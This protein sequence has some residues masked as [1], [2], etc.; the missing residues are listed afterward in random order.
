[1]MSGIKDKRKKNDSD[2]MSKHFQNAEIVIRQESDATLEKTTQF[3][4]R[5]DNE[6]TFSH[7]FS[8]NDAVDYTA[9]V[10][11]KWAR[12]KNLKVKREY[13]ILLK[14]N[15][16]LQTSF[17]N[18]EVNVSIKRRRSVVRT[19]DNSFDETFQFK[20][21]RSVVELKSTN[22]N[23]YYDKSYKEFKNWIRNALNAFEINSFYFLNEWKKIRWTQQY[24][25]KTSS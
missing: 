14:K 20:R 10:E 17:Q 9:L 7:E 3:K 25:R 4:T 18:D 5:D 6:K 19:S 1:M 13:Q 23:L 11:K 15:K 22:L 16:R 24:M 21:Q 8:E 12:N 2:E